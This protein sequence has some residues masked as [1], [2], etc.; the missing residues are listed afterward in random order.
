[1]DFQVLLQSGVQGRH[2]RGVVE[3]QRS[4]LQV[5]GEG[6]GANRQVRIQTESKVADDL[7]WC[8]QIAKRPE[9][10]PGARNEPN[11]NVNVAKR[12]RTVAK[13]GDQCSRQIAVS[14]KHSGLGPEVPEVSKAM[15]D[16]DKCPGIGEM[17]RNTHCATDILRLSQVEL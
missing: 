7:E 15:W 8:E 9:M 5:L 10:Q 4:G 6:V 12:H 16:G 3:C 17:H 1:M 11:V 13:F 2:P 14:S